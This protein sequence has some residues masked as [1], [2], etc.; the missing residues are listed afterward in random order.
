MQEAKWFSAGQL[1]A[2]DEYLKIGL[3][4]TG[5]HMVLV[6]TFFLLGQ[7]ITK[8]AVALLDDFPNLVSSTS[9]ILRLCDDLEGEKVI[10]VENY[11]RSLNNLDHII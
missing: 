5:V 2:A 4:S 9:T 10:S 11:N 1:P 3:V 6:H 8:E 7:G